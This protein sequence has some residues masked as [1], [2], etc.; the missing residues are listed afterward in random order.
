MTY[1]GDTSSFLYGFIWTHA[2]SNPTN[3]ISFTNDKN[4]KII[5]QISAVKAYELKGG[6]VV[7]GAGHTGGNLVQFNTPT[8]SLTMSCQIAQGRYKIRMRYASD[9]EQESY[10]NIS[11]ETSNSSHIGRITIKNTTHV[12]DAPH[13]KYKHFQYG[14]VTLQN[15]DINLLN[16]EPNVTIS[17]ENNQNIPSYSKTLID[18]IE[19]IPQ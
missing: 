17:I 14:S 11:I 5:T 4:Q 10:L 1:V 12:I 8:D 9:I 7:E 2:E 18:K 16:N 6:L 15:G 3:T 19:F 13:N